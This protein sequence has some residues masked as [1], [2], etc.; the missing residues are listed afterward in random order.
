MMTADGGRLVRSWQG[1]AI[2]VRA[3]SESRGIT[4]TGLKGSSLR[5]EYY[6]P[7][8]SKHSNSFRLACASPFMHFRKHMACM[9]AIKEALPV[10]HPMAATALFLSLF[11]EIGLVNCMVTSS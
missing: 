9:Y 10:W 8:T 5:L 7:F 11:L 4:R 6:V 3:A 2:D 1:R